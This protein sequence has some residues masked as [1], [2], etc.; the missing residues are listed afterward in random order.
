MFVTTGFLFRPPILT[1][2][3]PTMVIRFYANGG[4]NIGFKLMYTYLLGDQNNTASKTN[5]DCGGLVDNLGGAITMMEMTGEEEKKYNCFWLIKPP[6]G[7]MHIKT[8]LYAKVT[9]FQDFGKYRR[10]S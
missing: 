3:G 5:T 4:T 6:Q 7:Y 9:K 8:H 10:Y 2:S 1:S